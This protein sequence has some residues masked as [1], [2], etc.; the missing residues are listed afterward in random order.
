[1]CMS[2]SFTVMGLFVFP[3]GTDV[4]ITCTTKKSIFAK[5][6]E[7]GTL[8]SAKKSDTCGKECSVMKLMTP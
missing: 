5:T 3:I 6:K 2:P 7:F 4:R 1:M 8:K